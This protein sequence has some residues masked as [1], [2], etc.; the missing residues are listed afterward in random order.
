MTSSAR[1]G[2][3]VTVDEKLITLTEAAAIL[4]VAWRTVKKMVAKGQLTVV[5]V[6]EWERVR[7]SEVLEIL[8]GK[9]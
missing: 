3:P 1:D 6:G 8:H 4:G 7:K 5:P 9:G 2:I